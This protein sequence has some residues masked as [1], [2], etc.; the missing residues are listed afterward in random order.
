VAILTGVFEQL[1]IERM[2]LASGALR[3]GVLYDLVGRLEHEDVRERSIQAMMQRC[4][5]DSAQ[6]Q[7]VYD[8]AMALHAQAKD[9]WQLDSDTLIDTLR[10]AALLHEVGFAV[11]HTQFHKHGAYLLSN[12]DIAGFSRQEQDL[13]ALLVRGHRRKIPLK[14]LAQRE[15][16]EQQPLLRLILLLRIAVLLHHGRYEDGLPEIALSAKGGELV[17]SFPTGWLQAHPLTLADLEQESQFFRR[18][19]YLLKVS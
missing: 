1:G 6:A 8:A 7:R 11:S 3:E 5:V 10:W 2:E 17:L 16:E 18:A 14:L 13:V 19:G 15:V 12:S 4:H 9:A